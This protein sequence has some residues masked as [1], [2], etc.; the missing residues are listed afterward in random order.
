MP[1]SAASSGER[2]EG[3]AGDNADVL[4]AGGQSFRL[5]V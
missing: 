5:P 3:M 1:P 4:S 2:G